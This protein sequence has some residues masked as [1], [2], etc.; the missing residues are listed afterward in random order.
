MKNMNIEKKE[1]SVVIP[2]YNCEKSIKATLDSIFS[3]TFKE[4]IKEIIVINDGSTDNT[5][6][7]I[8]EYKNTATIKLI[9]KNILNMGVSNARNTGINIA[10]GK[11]IALC[12]SDDVWL[13]QKIEHQVKIINNNN[14][15]DFL[16]G[17]HLNKAQ[18]FFFKKIIGLKRINCNKLCFKMLPQ[19]ST[20]IFKKEIVDSIGGYDIKQMY[21]EDGNFF[22]KV[23]ANYN[24]FYDSDCVI[25][26]GNGK[27]GFGE[28]GLSKNIYEMHKGILKNLKEMKELNYIK[29]NIYIIALIYENI[30]YLRRKIIVKWKK[31]K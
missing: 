27:D 8:E 9:T 20:A 11:W 7:I 24:Y 21:A 30:K 13:P 17:N 12:D 1:I 14:E 22:M 6:K 25:C 10:T 28:S 16:G 19:T 31:R 3:Q 23:S 5:G 2:A 4:Y 29:F 26:Y 15:I 18:K